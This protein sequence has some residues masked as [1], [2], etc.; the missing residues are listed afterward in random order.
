MKLR[1]LTVAGMILFGAGVWVGLN[2]AT[3]L[4][5]PRQTTEELPNEEREVSTRGPDARVPVA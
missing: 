4:A 1:T 2:L 5:N 3:V